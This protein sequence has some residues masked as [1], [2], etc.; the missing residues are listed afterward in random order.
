ME[1]TGLFV[2]GCIHECWG[3]PFLPTRFVLGFIYPLY[4]I[5]LGTVPPAMK[6]GTNRLQRGYVVFVINN[7]LMIG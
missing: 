2:L 4:F 6:N 7:D 5:W 3:Y 1:F